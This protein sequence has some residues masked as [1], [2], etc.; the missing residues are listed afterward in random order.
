LP[1]LEVVRELGGGQR[2]PEAAVDNREVE[3]GES[4]WRQRLPHTPP[5]L[6]ARYGQLR[7]QPTRALA[8]Y[9]AE[10]DLSAMRI[11][12]EPALRR[13]LQLV[14]TGIVSRSSVT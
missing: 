13:L 7:I 3:Q 5:W 4:R 2:G 14:L 1:R 12:F 6:L 9:I 11:E 8:A 10:P